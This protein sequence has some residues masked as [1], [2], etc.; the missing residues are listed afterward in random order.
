MSIKRSLRIH[1]KEHS[2]PHQAQTRTISVTFLDICPPP[3]HLLFQHPNCKLL[4]H[5][6]I[7]P[8]HNP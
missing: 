8:S 5:I 1:L 2:T 4:C 7:G 3:Q 6:V